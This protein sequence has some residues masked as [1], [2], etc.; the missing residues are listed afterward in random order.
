MTYD[1][2]YTVTDIILQAYQE[3]QMIGDGEP[4]SGD[5]MKRGLRSLNRFI[6]ELQA[7]SLNL[8]T[9]QEGTLFLE[10]QRFEYRLE[11]AV[12]ANEYLK[13]T[14]STSAVA[15]ETTITVTDPQTMAVG[16]TFRLILDDKTALD[17]S[18]IGIAGNLITLNDA[19][20]SAAS[21]GRAIYSFVADSFIPISVIQDQTYRRVTNQNGDDYELQVNSYNRKEF[22]ALPDKEQPGLP[23]V[24]FYQRQDS[25]TRTGIIYVWTNPETADLRLTFS[26]YRKMC[27]FTLADGDSVLDAPAYFQ[28]ALILGLAYRLACKMGCEK[29]LFQDIKLKSKAAMNTVLG[30]NTSVNGRAIQISGYSRA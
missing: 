8:W 9:E 16:Y 19:L 14:L 29:N 13:T 17:T 25:T 26:Y 7:Y 27:V 21:A 12:L 20:P 24:G 3:L 1:I 11:N 6:Q 2:R 22:F 18:I 4:L 23:T 10:K 30:Y 5:L 15:T 28:H